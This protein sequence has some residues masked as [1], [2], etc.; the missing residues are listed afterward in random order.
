MI[1]MEGL[2]RYR[3][4]KGL[5]QIAR[6]LTVINASPLLYSVFCLVR[7]MHEMRSHEQNRRVRS[8][9]HGGVGEGVSNG[10]PNP[11]FQSMVQ[12]I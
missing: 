3:R 10:S 1:P 9:T 7:R 4:T 6:L 2:V 5:K 12:L 8:R 11:V